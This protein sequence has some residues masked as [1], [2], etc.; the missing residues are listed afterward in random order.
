[1]FRKEAKRMGWWLVSADTLAR[2]RFVISALAE[3]TASL[4]TLERGTAAHPGERAWLDTH[5]SGYAERLAS[6]PVAALLIRSTLAHRWI[7]DFLSPAPPGDGEAPFSDELAVVRQTPPETAHADLTVSL[8]GPLPAALQR[9]DLPDRAA[10]LLEWVWAETVLPYWPRR[11]R[12]IEADVVARTTQLSRGGWAAAMGGMR[13]GMRWLGE[14]RLQINAYNYPPR[15]ISGAQL[16]FVPVTC[17]RGWVAWDEP[18]RYAVIYPCSGALAEPDSASPPQAL[19]ALLGPARAS[20]LA[21]LEDPKSTSQ[22]VALTGFA[23]GSVGRHLKVLRDAGL[24]YRRR[25]GRTVLYARTAAGD[26][27]VEAATGSAE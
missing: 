20:I 7:A 14:G 16:L 4:I 12:I 8:A 10:S 3:T 22:L 18:H 13:E 15:E 24:A 17:S 21:L 11:R 5:R 1:M 19:G 26:A 25:A 27:L 6:D 23:L 9:P 2:S